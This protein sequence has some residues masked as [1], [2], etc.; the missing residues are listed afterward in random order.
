MPVGK[1]GE[2]RGFASIAHYVQGPGAIQ[3]LPQIVRELGSS[4]FVLVDGYF[5]DEAREKLSRLFQEEKIPV[6]MERF[7]RECSETEIGRVRQLIERLSEPADVVVGFGGGKTMDTAR[8]VA[9]QLGRKL[10]VAPTSAATNAAP[11]GMS[12]VYND[13]HEELYGTQCNKPDYVVADTEYILQA[14]ARMLAAGIADA[15]STYIEAR[16]IWRTHNINSVGPG[17]CPTICGRQ[18][19]KACYDTLLTYG[20]RAYL[21]AQRKLRTDPFEEV[22]EAITLLSGVGW[23]NNGCSVAHSLTSALSVVE[24][25]K[26]SLHGECV[27][28]CILVQLLLDNGD[29]DEFRRIYQFCGRLGL[30]RKLSQLGIREEVPA[31]LEKAV[32]FAFETQ[33]SLKIVNYELTPEKL[34][35]AIL[36]VDAL[37]PDEVSAQA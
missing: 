25:P 19:A 14:P 12:V 2:I 31:K 1:A 5:Y 37:T 33:R 16:N 13:D 24:D 4:A 29:W 27:A 34:L 7:G 26:H 36:F 10:I 30:P 3:R 32:R 9:T 8:V 23:E 17:Y 6:T 15:L 18:M 11:S 20:E 21:S 28:F 22:V 35:Q